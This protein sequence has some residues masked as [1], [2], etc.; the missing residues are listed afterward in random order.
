MR[1]RIEWD[2]PRKF[3]WQLASTRQTVGTSATVRYP[4]RRACTTAVQRLQRLLARAPIEVG[5]VPP[6]GTRGLRLRIGKTKNRFR[7]RLFD[8][9]KVAGE[10]ATT[11]STENAAR[12][13]A[14]R[15]RTAAPDALVPSLQQFAIEGL[16]TSW[17][18]DVTLRAIEPSTFG[19]PVGGVRLLGAVGQATV[20][21]TIWNGGETIVA[22]L[23]ETAFPGPHSLVVDTALTSG[24]APLE[25]LD[26]F[27]TAEARLGWGQDVTL[28]PVAPPSFGDIVGKVFLIGRGA[29]QKELPIVG[30]WS[31]TRLKVRL[32]DQPT[33]QEPHM[34]S[35]VRRATRGELPVVIDDVVTPAVR[36]KL[37]EL[38]GPIRLAPATP[39]VAPGETLNFPITSFPPDSISL[40]VGTFPV[41]VDVAW[42]VAGPHMPDAGWSKVSPL[43][44]S[45]DVTIVP[46]LVDMHVNT[47]PSR[48]PVTIEATVTLAA[49]GVTV[50]KTASVQIEAVAL[51]LPTVVLFFTHNYFQANVPREYGCVLAYVRPGSLPL[52]EERVSSELS[53]LQAILAK[54]A[55]AFSNGLPWLAAANETATRLGPVVH[56]V[57][58]ILAGMPPLMEK[59]TKL[60]VGTGAG[61][62]L[63]EDVKFWRDF[64]YVHTGEDN[65]GSIAVLG[66]PGTS[67]RMYS[68][69]NYHPKEGVLWIVVPDG[70]LATFVE[71]LHTSPVATWPPEGLGDEWEPDPDANF[72]NKLSSFHWNAERPD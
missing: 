56:S 10:S 27:R 22:H 63:L 35:V 23:P 7:W 54:L 69:R 3:R 43:P 49:A 33:F 62:R 68:A 4:T 51:E 46:R 14:E 6:A 38:L 47:E 18:Q 65:F 64:A 5:G 24:Q 70:Y 31:R 29:V 53:S 57:A 11:L 37:E 45:A 12:K 55:A 20:L 72:G 36:A 9:T 58:T 41:T 52:N 67:V 30:S 39:V 28:E 34:L 21:R 40:P 61:M 42:R 32:P 60:R 1:F 8:G 44:S 26:V 19:L 59:G 50:S 48:D 16:P 13:A 71:D 66:R 15:F 2:K 17:G 25:V